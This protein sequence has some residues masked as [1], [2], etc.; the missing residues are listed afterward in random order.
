MSVDDDALLAVDPSVGRY[1]SRGGHKLAAAIET[2]DIAVKGR[3]ALDVGASTGG[4]TDCLL[5]LGAAQVVAVDVGS[6]QLHESLRTNPRVVSYE[7]TDIRRL[8]PVVVQAPFD[9]VVVDVSFISLRV[10]A[11]R[12]VSFAGNDADVVV[13]V[14]PQFEAG[15]GHHTKRGVIVDPA[16]RDASC[17]AVSAAFAAVGLTT[18]G[19]IMSPLEGAAGNREYLLWLRSE[20]GGPPSSPIGED[21][22]HE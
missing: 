10:L 9:M 3:R 18:Q 21:E 16:V 22:A 1:V 20:S 4:F 8:D 15:P 19:T 14:K 11:S 7:G 17:S 5:K 12:L 13:L 2:F 6:R